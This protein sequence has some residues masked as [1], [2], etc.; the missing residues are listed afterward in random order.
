MV[1]PAIIESEVSPALRAYCEVT[2]G[3]A[4]YN[5]KNDRLSDI[6]QM[7]AKMVGGEVSIKS[8]IDH[9][10]EKLQTLKCE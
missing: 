4:W 3:S 8:V 9:L 5:S 1:K 10:L 2:P 6:D 7:M